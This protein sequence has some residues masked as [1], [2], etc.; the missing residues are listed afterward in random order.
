MH[1]DTH[2]AR[3]G[4]PYVSMEVRRFVKLNVEYKLNISGSEASDKYSF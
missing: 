1:N 4:L 2:G 3:T